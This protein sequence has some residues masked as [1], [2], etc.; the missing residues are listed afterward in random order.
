MAARGSKCLST[1]LSFFPAESEIEADV[2]FALL[3]QNDRL[4]CVKLVN[5][6]NGDAPSTV[7]SSMRNS[8]TL[9][10][11]DLDSGL[12][13]IIIDLLYL[14]PSVPAATCIFF[15]THSFMPFFPFW[16]LYLVVGVG[17]SFC[18]L[19][20]FD[21]SCERCQY[22]R[23]ETSTEDCAL[24]WTSEPPPLS[25]HGCMEPRRVFTNSTQPI[26][27]FFF[28]F[29]S[30]FFLFF[31]FFFFFLSRTNIRVSTF[32]FSTFSIP[33]LSCPK[34]F[35]MTAELC[36]C[37]SFFFGPLLVAQRVWC[38]DLHLALPSFPSCWQPF[39]SP[40]PWLFF[41]TK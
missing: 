20:T 35:Q 11:G 40:F 31:S 22:E 27:F 38:F 16:R 33:I 36:T 7:A 19:L 8:S 14:H 4:I 25:L 15:W 6:L 39:P 13:R 32:S 3:A 1:F 17:V 26:F 29:F 30:M 34:N 2:C 18:L 23:W 41:E 21:S 10:E 5:D 12:S 37:F 9:P 24:N 28:F